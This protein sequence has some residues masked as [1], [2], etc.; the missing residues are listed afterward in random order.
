L[1]I[2]PGK[3]PFF[4]IFWK[5]LLTVRRKKIKRRNPIRKY[6]RK[7]LKNSITMRKLNPEPLLLKIQYVS[8]N[9][10]HQ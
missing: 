5:N 10:N 7:S 2:Q 6:K 9:K 3:L 1:I 4:H 8:K